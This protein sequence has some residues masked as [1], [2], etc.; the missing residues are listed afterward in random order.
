VLGWFQTKHK[1][2]HAAVRLSKLRLGM[3]V[4][5]TTARN[6]EMNTHPAL[7]AGRVAVITGA[8][9]GI[10]LAAALR[11][12]S[13]GMKV[14]LADL[15]PEAAAEQVATAS[16]EGASA[17]LAVPTDVSKLDAVEALCDA[18][19]ARF[20][21]VGVLMN[22]AGVSPGGGPYD[23]IGQWRSL[24]EVNL[25]GVINGV[26]TFVPRMLAQKTA[27]A[28]VN[29]GSKQ[30]ITCP[31]GNTAYNV[32]KAG[33]KVLTE[34]LAHSLRNEHG[35]RISAHLLI[36]GST[37]T[38]MTR[39]DRREKPPG[40]W[41]PAQVVDMLIQG[42]NQGDFYILCPDNEVTREIDNRRILWAAGDITENRPALSRWHPDYASAFQ[43]FL[44]ARG[45]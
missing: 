16:P 44:Q 35:A 5:G 15:A 36:P 10:G 18:A 4:M 39:G 43:A 17:V 40:A 9:S 22:N 34:A 3:A 21:E 7:A 45:S 42:V 31:P 11:F 28:V 38:A 14:C 23:N 6:L 25:W 32:S 30:G 8:A 13:L 41:T 24:L 19:Y 37:F 33:V 2:P 12:A 20:G 26:Q 1:K 29:T 27:C